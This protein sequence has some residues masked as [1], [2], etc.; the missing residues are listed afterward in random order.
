VSVPA[1]TRLGPYQILS[2][3]GAGGMGEVYKARDTRLDRTVAI[4]ILSEAL[5]G[6]PQFRERFDRE[7]R[8]ISQLTHPHICT[9]YDVGNQEGMAF[10]VMECLEGET[11]AH[12]LEQ[13]ALPLDDALVVAIEIAAALGSAHRNGVVHRDLKPGNVMLTKL[14][15]KL[16]DFGLAKASGPAIGGGGLSMLPTTPN[17]TA[18]GTILGTF[19]YMAPEQLEGREIDGR[20]DIFAFGTVLYEMLTG[21]KAFSGASH[22]SLISSI[23]SSHPPSISRTQTLAPAELDHLVARCLA[24]DPEDRWQS[25]RDLELQLSWIARTR[26]SPSSPAPA[27][28]S[29][30]ERLAWA[31]AGAALLGLIA[32]V[33]MIVA[34]RRAPATAAEPVQLTI[35]PPEKASFSADVTGQALSADGKQIV[36]VAASH[37]GTPQLWIRRLDSLNARLIAGTEGA[38]QP[39]WSPDGRFIG[40][41][42][43]GALKTIGLT[44]GPPQT[45]A[46]ASVPLGGTWNR[47]GVILFGR[48][49]GTPIVRVSAGGG[50][51]TQVTSLVQTSGIAAHASP[52]FLPDGQHFFFVAATGPTAG[53]TYIGSLDSHDARLLFRSN[54]AAIYSPSGHVLFLRESTLM[55]QRFDLAT[56]STRGEAVAVAEG[57]GRSF[58]SISFL[59]S[60]NGTL[61]YR[62]AM[63]ANTRPTWVSRAGEALAGAAPAGSYE[64][65]SLSPDDTR[66]AFA[67]PGPTGTDVWLTDLARGITSRFTFRPPLNNVPIWSSDGR[68]IV[69]A[70]SSG[71][72]LNL[73]RRASDASGPDELLLQLN[74]QPLLFPSD[75]SADGRFLI[76]YR[77]D[78]KT[79]LDIWT[80]PLVG[81]R[82]SNR[83]GRSDAAEGRKA[84]PFLRGEYNESQGQLSPDGRW[85]A[86]VSDESGSQQVYVQSFPTLGGQRQVSSAG[87][88]QPRWRRDG[89]ELFYLAPD[90]RLMAVAVKTGETFEADSPR[91]LFRTELNAAAL[92][93][94]YAVS[95]DGQ[96]FLLNVSDQAG[97]PP[98]TVVLNWPALLKP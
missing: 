70:S 63:A 13:G 86:Y 97:S 52:F 54:S 96:R 94:S 45:L 14:G 36:F 39:F 30:R 77:T 19:Q 37:E 67:R 6:D 51:T 40:F 65:M 81:D 9:L 48:A 64:E 79:Q 29:S 92:R 42:A 58:L 93:Q 98:M 88:N 71:G 8:A 90:R 18:Q 15:A 75:W 73:H 80:L 55:A 60:D 35:L 17:L 83:S 1:G 5:A 62:P 24:K 50:A 68:Q 95:L 16:L 74:A 46:E 26:P 57:V 34:A 33:A 44:G 32:A 10:L 12:R 23:M 28:R 78:P 3:L 38:A 22:A 20:T 2:R 89:K 84:I 11:L 91:A 25:A 59:A 85:M 31:L 7:A 27:A 69:F 49:L 82:P 21:A 61:V 87:G 4:K 53:D 66:V 47:D 41:F 76:Y 72:L 43:A 56:L